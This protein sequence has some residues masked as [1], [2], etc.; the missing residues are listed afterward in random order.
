[1]IST[2]QSQVNNLNKYEYEKILVKW[3]KPEIKLLKG[4]IN[5]ES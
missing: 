5:N 2:E 4:V 1:M 3:L